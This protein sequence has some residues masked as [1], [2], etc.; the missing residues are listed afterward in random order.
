[1]VVNSSL[2]LRLVFGRCDLSI[3]VQQD[4]LM[5]KQDAISDSFISVQ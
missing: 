4:H 1:M 5:G 2:E 3:Q